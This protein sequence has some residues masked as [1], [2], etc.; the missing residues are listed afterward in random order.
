VDLTGDS[1]FRTNPLRT[2]HVKEP[3]STISGEICKKI[4]KEWSVLF[5]KDDLPHSSVNSM[6]DIRMDPHIR[7]R[8]MLADMDQP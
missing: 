2:K 4:T 5:E 1:K 6:K 8:N 3:I 7:N